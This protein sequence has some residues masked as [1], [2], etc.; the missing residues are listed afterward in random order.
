MS[1]YRLSRQAH[2]D[3]DD[4]WLYIASD[5]VAAAD[6]FVDEFT[7]KFRLLATQPGIGRSRDEFAESLRSLPVGN[8]IIF[9]R[10]IDAGVEV[11]RVLSGFRDI[12]SILTDDN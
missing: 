3:L 5:S 10:P 11:V 4:I 8:Y 1:R 2:I 6:R 9:Y 7:A 12:P